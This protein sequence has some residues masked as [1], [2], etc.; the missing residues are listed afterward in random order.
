M[1]NN[2]SLYFGK[3]CEHKVIA[4]LLNN[5]YDV[6]LPIVDNKGIDV[7][8]K[9]KDEIIY[10][11]I[12]VKGR[13]PRWIFTIKKFIPR[14]NYYF[15]FLPKDGCLYVVPSKKVREWF[16]R[17]NGISFNNR[18]KNELKNYQ[19]KQATDKE[20]KTFEELLEI[21]ELSSTSHII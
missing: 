6:Y 16:N 15:A 20:G 5:E 8:I 4:E 10:K 17:K 19:Y 12:Q 7:V 3:W 11:E 14:E 1:P 21:S 2:N 18:M 9:K 13:Q